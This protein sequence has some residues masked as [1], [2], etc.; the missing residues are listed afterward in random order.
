LQADAPERDWKIVHFFGYDNSFYHAILYPVLYRLAFPDW[1]PDID[2]HVNEFYLLDNQKFST[3][4]KHAIW[5]RDILSP[6]SVDAV[7]YFLS[8]TRPEGRRTNFDPAEYRAVLQGT[9]IGSWQ[10]WLHDL[11]DRVRQWYG[12]TAP[13]AGAWTPEQV[14]FLARL[15]TRLTAITGSL[16]RDGFSLNQASAE[17][18][19]LVEDVIRFAAQEY[20]VA[21]IE[22]WKSTTRTSIALEL[23]TARLIARCACPIMPRFAARLTAALGLPQAATWPRAVELVP[24]GTLVELGVDFF[25]ADGGTEP[26][27]G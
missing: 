27:D 11:G 2:Y 8:R 12:G 9:L 19:G 20:P 7:R 1:E 10:R 16:G 17:L 26:A 18:D 25:P 21:G 6:A 14:A 4:R 24:A 13:D 3:S 22:V 5:G 15:D 23:A